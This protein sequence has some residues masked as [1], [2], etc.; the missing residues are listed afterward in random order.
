MLF[1]VVFFSLG[2]FSAAGAAFSWST[3]VVVAVTDESAVS[4]LMR[5]DSDEI[6]WS[7]YVVGSVIEGGAVCA[8]DSI[9]KTSEDNT[10]ISMAMRIM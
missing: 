8:T 1:G 10:A 5:V 7:L 9:T 4:V 2:V 6:S 3:V